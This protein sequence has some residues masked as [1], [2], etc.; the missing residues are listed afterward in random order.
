MAVIVTKFFTLLA[1]R[2]LISFQENHICF[3]T[4]YK[5]SH[6]KY[7]EIP[8]NDLLVKYRSQAEERKKGGSEGQVKSL[9]VKVALPGFSIARPLGS[10]V[11]L[12]N[13]FLHSSPEAPRIIPMFEISTSEGGNSPPPPQFCQWV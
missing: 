12:P 4:V 10:I 3:I 13:N 9:K 6:A 11:F 5:K 2:R 8:S 1:L 7:H